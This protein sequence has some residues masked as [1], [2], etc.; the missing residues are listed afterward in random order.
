MKLIVKLTL[1]LLFCTPFTSLAEIPKQIINDFAPISGTIIMPL[2]DKYLVDLDASTDLREG[3][4]L[5]LLMAGEKIIQPDTKKVIGTLDRAKGFLQ[6][7]QVKS[8]YSY[9][10]P[11][12]KGVTPQKGDRVKRFEQIPARFVST[13]PASPLAEELKLALPQLHWLNNSDQTNP[14][15]IF[16]LTADSLTVTNSAGAE[17]KSYPYREGKLVVSMAGIHQVDN[18][19]L[20]GTPQ[21]NKSLLNQAVSNLGVITGLGIKDKRLENPGITQ[22]QQLNDGIWVGP[23][24]GGNP[25][26]IA[27]ADFDGDGQIETAVAME[28]QLQILRMTDGKLSPIAVVEFP[29]GVHLLS[30]DVA[31]INTDNSPELYLSANV[32]T[33]LSSQVVEFSDGNYHRTISRVPWF[34][35]VV[36]LP[37]EGRTLLAQTMG[38]AE[39]HF[40]GQPFRVKRTGDKLTRGNNFPL[41]AGLNLYSFTALNGANNDLLYASISGNDKLYVATPR[42]ATLWEAT[43][44]F[45]GTEVYFYNAED[46]DKNLIQPVFIQQRL[47][48]LPDGEILAAQNDGLRVLERYRNFDKSRVIALKWD[49][50]ALQQKWSTSDQAGYL[51]DF[52]VADADNDGQDELVMVIKYKQKNLLQKGRSNVVI[53]E[54]NH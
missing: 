38:D 49:G 30:L 17:L 31:D 3:D 40:F 36:E 1:L 29:S 10:K 4:I 19:Q 32:G 37:Q 44:H 23:N 45:G 43:D 18:F 34:L 7:T 33:K 5:T 16:S 21:K 54:L 52:T 28:N 2:G 39:N 53:Y 6:V 13:L 20:G 8:G 11:L 51:A 22:N 14:E 25:I 50:V 35:R 12:H 26:G 46:T 47:V 15:L 24:L 9:V 42:G 41:P 48:T 27:V